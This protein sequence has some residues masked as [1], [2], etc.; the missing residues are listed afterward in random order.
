M[1]P[2]LSNRMRRSQVSWHHTDFER[3][4]TY[5]HLNANTCIFPVE[6]RDH[7]PH[8]TL[9]TQTVV[10]PSNGVSKLIPV[11][12]SSFMWLA[13]TILDKADANQTQVLLLTF[14]AVYLSRMF[15]HVAVGFFF[16][17]KKTICFSHKFLPSP[18]SC[19]C[20]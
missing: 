17:A 19:E 6:C 13:S 10:K 18:Q 11:H 8:M 4:R 20:E 7:Q 15:R 1:L 16:Y 9:D 5:L 3:C 12:W 2:L 14:A